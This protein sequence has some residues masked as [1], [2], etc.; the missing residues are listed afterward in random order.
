MLTPQEHATLKDIYMM[1][2]VYHDFRDVDKDKIKR[3]IDLLNK[4]TSIKIAVDISTAINYA[5]PIRVPGAQETNV[6]IKDSRILYTK[7]KVGRIFN[8]YTQLYANIPKQLSNNEVEVVPDGVFNKIVAKI[9]LSDSFDK[10]F[11]RALVGYINREFP[12][13][14]IIGFVLPLITAA[15]AEASKTEINI[16]V[17]MNTLNS[18]IIKDFKSDNYKLSAKNLTEAWNNRQ[19][20]EYLLRCI[21]T[22]LNDEAKPSNDLDF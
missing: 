15:I 12:N 9:I 5:V 7:K 14:S 3:T 6:L 20:W 8:Y 17:L 19:I 11:V 4:Y 1:D 16:D 2:D 13:K 10:K 18:A 21:K 22:P